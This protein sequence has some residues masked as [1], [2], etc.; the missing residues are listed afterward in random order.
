MSA[1]DKLARVCTVSNAKTRERGNGAGGVAEGE[2]GGGG[3]AVC[4]RGVVL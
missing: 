2:G 4:V 3:G 1:C